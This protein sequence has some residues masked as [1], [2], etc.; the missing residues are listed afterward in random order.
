MKLTTNQMAA[1]KH[2]NGNALV[3][4][5]AGSGKT[6]VFTSRIANLIANE[7]VNPESILGLTFTKDAAENMRKRLKGI[8]GKSQSDKVNLS[9]FH[10][11]AYRFLVSEF[12]LEY[13]NVK[14]TQDWW[15]LQTVYDII[16]KSS[17]R[18]PDALDL[19]L[20]GGE[21]LAFISY[22]K[23]NMIRQGNAVLIDNNTPYVKGISRDDL[24]EAFDRYCESVK[25][26][27]TMD[28]DDMLINTFYKLIENPDLIEKFKSQYKYI[29]VDEYQDTSSI[30]LE[31]LKL[32]S[33]N[34][35]FVV[36]D[37]RQGIYGF[38]N[39][40]IDNILEFT[41]M[42]EDVS[43]IELTDNFR[44]TDNIVGICNDIIGASDNVKY[45]GFSSA[46]GASGEDGPPVRV[47]V[48]NSE[49]I[50]AEHIV[51]SIEGRIE[52]NPDLTF[53]DFC[54]LCRT[55][56]Q[57]GIFESILADRDIPARLSDARSFFDRKEIADVLAYAEHAINPGDDMS[58][59]R[60]FNSPTRYISR[61]IL[62]KLDEHAFKLDSSLEESIKTF[63]NDSRL[64]SV[65]D[66]FKK[67][68]KF[69]NESAYKFLTRILYFTNYQEFIQQKGMSASEIILKEESLERLLEMSKKFT[70]IKSFLTHVDIIKNNSKKKEIAV[71][72]MTSHS[73]KGLEF[74]HVYVSNVTAENYP[75]KMTIDPEEERRLLYV[76]L[77]RAIE[78]LDV[79]MSVN[80][81]GSESNVVLASPFLIDIMETDLKKAMSQAMHGSDTYSFTYKA[82]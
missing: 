14:I 61:V 1:V 32:I 47:T 26:A 46:N 63:Q 70:S 64:E 9:T 44:S 57:L 18:N 3:N 76:A 7:K 4:S 67:I 58:L 31:I 56:A 36:G 16:G 12:P 27:R 20:R 24:Q 40:N 74:K 65:V 77:S 55:N 10:S 13:Q 35:L 23:S 15:K 78:T 71:N 42:F 37:F 68:R 79:S 54:I 19:D 38:I 29:M 30:N 53:N 69:Q 41:D 81:L 43:L 34:N 62:N 8:V 6:A 22:Q 5:S 33:E 11:F 39:A 25:H 72:V 49:V 2:T 52:S 75:H 80:T 48:C 59:R 60:I 21:M 51:K 82:R 45:K 73:S 66:L 28:F 50:E 17:N